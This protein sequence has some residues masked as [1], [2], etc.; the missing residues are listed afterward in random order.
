MKNDTWLDMGQANSLRL[1]HTKA[2]FNNDSAIQGAIK[3]IFKFISRR[4]RRSLIY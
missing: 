1:I 4:A 2:V 3:K